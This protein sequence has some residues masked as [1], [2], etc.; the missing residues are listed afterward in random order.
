MP[1]TI[2]KSIPIFMLGALL[3]GACREAAEFTVRPDTSIT[4]TQFPGGCGAQFVATVTEDDNEVAGLEMPATTTEESEV[5]ETWTGNDYSYQIRTSSESDADPEIQPDEVM[6]ATF[7]SGVI[8]PTDNLGQPTGASGSIDPTTFDLQT[9]SSSERQASYDD[10]YYGIYTGCPPPEIICDPPNALVV[11]ESATR[12]AAVDP[13]AR[14]GVAR[15][16]VRALIAN[17][18]ELS[19]SALG[20]R[21]FSVRQPQGETIYSVDPVNDLLMG[22]EY[23]SG[24]DR[25]SARYTWVPTAGGLVKART[26]ITIDETRNGKRTT[27]RATIAI[28]N[29]HINGYRI[30]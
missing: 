11:D 10:P 12:T 19:R 30:H 1:Q 28:A 13:L 22:Q 25:V 26:D 15:R 2:P 23:V 5:C 8:T 18:V 21:R 27:S 17:G 20:E 14:H 24:S 9:A 3:L 16:G 6:G 7:F 29:V 4:R